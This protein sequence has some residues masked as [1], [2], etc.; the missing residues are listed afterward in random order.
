M[1]NGVSE[2]L[3]ALL[4]LNYSNNLIL[5]AAHIQNDTSVILRD[6]K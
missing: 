1:K 3:N 4:L 6:G 5:H 2:K